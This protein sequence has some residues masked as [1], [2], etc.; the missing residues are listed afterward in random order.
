MKMAMISMAISCLLVVSSAV[1]GASRDPLT[2]SLIPVTSK[3]ELK[4]VVHYTH[5][6]TLH[7]ARCFI[8][9]VDAK[10]YCVL[11]WRGRAPD[12]LIN[13]ARLNSFNIRGRTAA[14]ITSDLAAHNPPLPDP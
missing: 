5:Q 2:Y 11:K 10:L 9:A 4:R 6:R 7:G 14:Q 1:F 13:F 3:S 8:S 12:E